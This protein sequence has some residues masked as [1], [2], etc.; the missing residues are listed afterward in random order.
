MQAYEE[1]I[2]KTS[3]QSAPWYVV[4]ANRNWYR[5]LVIASVIAEKMKSLKMAYP[6]PKIDTAEFKK[7]LMAG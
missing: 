3:T 5:N 6:D 4:P 7:Q 2:Q 1:A